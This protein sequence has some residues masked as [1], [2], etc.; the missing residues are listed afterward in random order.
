MGHELEK[1]KSSGAR[2]SLICGIIGLVGC[3]AMIVADI[4]GIII[5]EKH[6]PFS[7]TISELAN[8]KYGWVQD[9][10]LDLYAAAMIACAIGLYAWNLD[11]TRW[12]IAN[13]C[14]ILLGIDVI[15]IADHNQYVGR[16]RVG[17][18]IH[19]FLVY[20]FAFLFT[21]LTVLIGFGLRRIGQK[22]YRYSLATS[23]T[24][25]VLAPIFFVIPT[26]IDGAY[27]RFIALITI[28]WVTAISWLLIKTRE[29]ELALTSSESLQ[30]VIEQLVSKYEKYR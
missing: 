9:L 26:S 15:L 27:E 23:I 16:P 14:L 4:V 30:P 24:W 12:K 22:W 6:N 21:V 3:L 10:G 8:E 1:N 28:A 17:S 25:T 2:R 19:F 11:G 5:V 18:N 7:D 20:V 13:I 29:G